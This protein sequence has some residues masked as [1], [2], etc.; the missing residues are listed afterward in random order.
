M[1]NVNP[2]KSKELT[3]FRNKGKEDHIVLQVRDACDLECPPIAAANAALSP[4]G[5]SSDSGVS[6]LP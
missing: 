4:A 5:P 3:N 6:P 1:L 2:T